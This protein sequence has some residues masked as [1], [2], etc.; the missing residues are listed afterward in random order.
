LDGQQIP[1]QILLA[2]KILII[3][4]EYLPIQFCGAL[5]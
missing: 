3:G 1:H 2:G 4:N 5:L